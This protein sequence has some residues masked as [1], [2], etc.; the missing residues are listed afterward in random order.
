MRAK[1]YIA[2]TLC[3]ESNCEILKSKRQCIIFNK[4]IIFTKYKTELKMKNLAL[5]FR[6]MN[7][8]L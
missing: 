6:E 3:F 2:F 5:C 7:L 4:N 8:V 1:I